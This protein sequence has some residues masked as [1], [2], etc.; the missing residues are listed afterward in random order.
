VNATILRGCGTLARASMALV[1]NL[2]PQI[3]ATMAVLTVS[4]PKAFKIRK[5]YKP[6]L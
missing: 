4:T 5:A 6:L 2:S 3:S 1:V